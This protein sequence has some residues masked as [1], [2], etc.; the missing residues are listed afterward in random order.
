MIYL[1]FCDGITVDT[2]VFT[3]LTM[4][5]NVARDHRILAGMLKVA[6][7]EHPGVDFP[8]LTHNLAHLELD[9]SNILISSY[10]SPCDFTQV[11]ATVD[12]IVIDACS[13]ERHTWKMLHGL[14]ESPACGTIKELHLGHDGLI[15]EDDETMKM[16]LSGLPAL[17]E[18][19]YC[20]YYADFDV[21]ECLQEIGRSETVM[22]EALY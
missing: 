16:V 12:T 13:S 10:S 20:G 21:E 9:D 15:K 14:L 5:S 3:L 4:T 18:V 1:F 22:C 8:E 2:F 11:P 19:T 6:Q 17:E 7:E